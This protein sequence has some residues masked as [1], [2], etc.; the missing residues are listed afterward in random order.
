MELAHRRWMY[1]RTYPHRSGLREEFIEGLLNLWEKEKGRLM[2]YAE[3]FEDKH[4]KKKKN[5]TREWVEPRASTTYEAYQ[6]R[7][8]EWRQRQLDSEDGSSAQVSL[9]DVTSIWTQVVGGAKKGRIYGL[10][11]QHSIGHSTT[12][13]SGEASYS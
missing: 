10:G 5:G 4:M 1:S 8:E 9:N 3:V 13:L 11:S 12:L 7:L 2:T 6:N